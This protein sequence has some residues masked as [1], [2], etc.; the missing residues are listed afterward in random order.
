MT[1]S[2]QHVSHER[3]DTIEE[4]EQLHKK[5]DNLA[6]RFDERK[7]LFRDIV[8]KTVFACLTDNEEMAYQILDQLDENIEEF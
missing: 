5:L 7:E 4:L 6:A 1:T 2:L 3:A 8:T